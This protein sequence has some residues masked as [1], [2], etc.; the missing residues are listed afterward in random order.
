MSISNCLLEKILN[1]LEKLNKRIAIRTNAIAVIEIDTS[2]TTKRNFNVEKIFGTPKG[3]IATQLT[4]IDLG[5]EFTINVNNS[6]ALDAVYGYSIE[7]EEINDVEII[8]SGVAGT[9]KIR[10]GATM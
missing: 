9:A 1:E 10:I 4:I 5:G 3:I 8:G 7:N 2:I 6:G